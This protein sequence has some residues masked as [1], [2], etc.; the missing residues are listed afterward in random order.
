MSAENVKIINLCKA[1][2]ENTILDSVNLEFQKGT[3][4]CIMGESGVGKTTLLK[5]M[6]GLE[7]MD[8][9][10]I[11]GIDELT[12]FS[13]VFQE[14]R[15]CEYLTGV[16]NIYMVCPK[17]ISRD[18]IHNQLSKILPQNALSKKVSLLSGG[19]RQ[20]VA[21]ARAM[22]VPSDIILMD[23]PFKGLDEETKKTVIAYIKSSQCDRTIIIV[24]HNQE[25]AQMLQA[26]ICV[27]T[28]H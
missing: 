7:S 6:M 26:P 11:E 2:G 24:T 3:I 21:I 17:N 22:I 13:V 25:E 19:M 4:N 5:I 15:L 27:L 18:Y 10:C 14:D 9:G 23:E 1:Y 16:G 20:R 8:T 28:K 12:K